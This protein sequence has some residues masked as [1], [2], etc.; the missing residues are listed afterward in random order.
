MFNMSFSSRISVFSLT[1]FLCACTTSQPEPPPQPSS[2]HT[3]TLSANVAMPESP[4]FEPSG[5][6]ITTV[7]N[8]MG[9]KSGNTRIE[10]LK[11]LIAR[12][13]IDIR[14][15]IL[16]SIRKELEKPGMP[17]KLVE[18][19]GEADLQLSVEA[20]GMH[21][22]FEWAVVPSIDIQANLVDTNGT[23]IWDSHEYVDQ[24]HEFRSAVRSNTFSA[25]QDDPEQLKADYTAN[26]AWVVHNLIDGLK[27][28][29]ASG[30]IGE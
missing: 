18:R 5:G 6:A 24:R 30:D 2:L 21:K 14:Q 20:Y 22:G 9:A 1:L 13:D 26:I 19:G 10:Q 4:E 25:Y 8:A 29:H 7:L 15:M 3:I 28:D 16:S 27:E 23:I 11:T 12:G 17:I